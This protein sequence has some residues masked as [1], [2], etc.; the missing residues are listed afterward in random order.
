ML[1]PSLI[2]LTL[3]ALQLAVNV[4]ATRRLLASA[5]YEPFQ[6]RIQLAL[7]WFLPL[8]GVILVWLFLNHERPAMDG[9]AQ[10]NEDDDVPESLWAH[11]DSSGTDS[12]PAEAS[13]NGD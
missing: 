6:K 4:I 10:E 11:R 1:F 3:F 7:I 13:G 5:F 2:V 12:P 9:K 8:F